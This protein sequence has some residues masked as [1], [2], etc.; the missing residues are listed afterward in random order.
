MK[1]AKRWGFK[2]PQELALCSS[3]NQ[4]IDFVTQWDEG[5]HHLPCITMV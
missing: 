5:R 3:I 2:I 4:V 1:A